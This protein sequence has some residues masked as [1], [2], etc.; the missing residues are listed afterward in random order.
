MLVIFSGCSGVGKNTVINNLLSKSDDYK[1]L[2]TYTT[3]DKRPGE[4]DGFPYFFIND[5]QFLE[6][7][8]K[9]DFYEHELVHN[10]YY[11]TS[12]QL[13]ADGLASGKTLM[14]DIDVNGALN[15]SEIL[16]NDVRIITL[17]LY[18]ES[19]DILVERLTGRGEK[20]I[21][22]RLERYNHEMSKQKLYSYLI[23]NNSLENT[24]KL[25][26]ELVKFEKS[27][28]KLVSALEE[29]DISENAVK[30]ALEIY[31]RGENPEPVKVSV[32]DG[33]FCIT[34]GVERFVASLVCGK[35]IAKDL[36][37]DESAAKTFTGFDIYGY[38]K[39]SF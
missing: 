24:S 30:E 18:V 11:G 9:G 10:H 38:A 2:P 21:A 28:G 39:K 6:K 26:D 32:C 12:R 37:L 13:L 35:T 23:N 34:E 33:V 25:I 5:E 14:K 31:A 3:R 4:R 20:D 27:E 15:L 36:T 29:N 19:A 8:A 22:L 7:I 1:L 16:K 17:F